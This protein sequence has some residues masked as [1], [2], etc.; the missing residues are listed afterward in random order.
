RSNRREPAMHTLGINAAFHD[1]AA[2]LVTDGQVVAAAEEERFSRIKHGKRPL[3]YSSWELPF[4]AIDYCLSQ[5]GLTLADVDHVAYS[6]APHLAL[7]PDFGD[8]VT[9]PL[10]PVVREVPTG[11]DPVWEPLM[12]AS[13]RHAPEHLCQ[14]VP[15]HLKGRFAGVS[16]A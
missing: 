10:K 7:P 15:H 3:P 9:L 8:W 11:L 14:S 1:H 13:I 6:F 12:L 16:A 4:H 5:G 2:C